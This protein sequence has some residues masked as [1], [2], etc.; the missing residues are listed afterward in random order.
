[1]TLKESFKIIIKEFHESALPELISRHLEINLSILNSPVKKFYLVDQGLHNFLTFRF[2]E[3]K[4][5]VLE[6]IVFSQLRRN[7]QKVCYYKTKNGC[8]QTSFKS[9]QV[10]PNSWL[11]KASIAQFL[12]K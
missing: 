6:N 3:N 7:G 1:M 10:L 12:L 2:S 4:G 9:R 8:S 11:L 5:K